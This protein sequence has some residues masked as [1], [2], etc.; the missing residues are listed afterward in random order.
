MNSITKITS[1]TIPAVIGLGAAWIGV[2]ILKNERKL[3]ER[4][5]ELEIQ[6]GA[7]AIKGF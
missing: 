3:E 1:I 2:R 6:L 5:I 4:K 7:R